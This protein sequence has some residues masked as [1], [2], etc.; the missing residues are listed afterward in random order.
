MLTPAR[1]LAHCVADDGQMLL[2]L[3]AS[4]VNARGACKAPH[5]AT[6]YAHAF[7]PDRGYGGSAQQAGVGGTHATAD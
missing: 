3:A 5:I 7:D 6:A 4:L 2:A 1:I